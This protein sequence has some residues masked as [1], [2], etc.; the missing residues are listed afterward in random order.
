MHKIF[1]IDD[2]KNVT[3]ML[4]EYLSQNGFQC[5]V[6][7]Q[8]DDIFSRILKAKPDIIVCDVIMT[9][10]SGFDIYYR[11][12]QNA[13]TAKIPF[14]LL[15]AQ[16]SRDDVIKGL[17]IGALD[18]I[19]KPINLEEL[20]ERLNIILKSSV[21]NAE[22]DIN[23]LLAD[24][25]KVIIKKT[26]Q[27][28]HNKGYNIITTQTIDEGIELCN[29]EKIDVVIS[30]INL[31]GGTG[32]SFCRQLKKINP[33]IYFMLLISEGNSEALSLGN[34][35]GVDDFVLKNLG[36]DGLLVKINQIIQNRSFQTTQDKT[37]DIADKNVITVL[38]ACEVQGFTGKLVIISPHG[39]GEIEM[40]RSEYISI[41]FNELQETDALEA[42]AELKSGKIIIKPVE[43]VI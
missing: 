3:T 9:P 12:K 24:S 22:N 32:Y 4:D 18:Y 16:N 8:T 42:L 26:Q 17:Q 37:Y 38:Q 19:T 7:N 2:D 33:D 23:I 39:N 20:R 31:K 34:N 36:V 1:I 15:S 14:V 29:S 28:L 5:F 21:K 25:S 40:Q 41:R 10:L 11:L 43:M 35:A 13:N 6:A 30:G 27:E